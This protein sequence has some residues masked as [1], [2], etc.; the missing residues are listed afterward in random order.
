MSVESKVF[1]G[2]SKSV[3]AGLLLGQ[4]AFGQLQ[5]A[6]PV[7]AYPSSL[8]YRFS[9]V[10]WWSD[11]ELRTLLKKRIP[12]LGD[13]VATTTAGE[14]KIR[15]ALKILL[16]EK[17]IAAEVQSEEPGP[18]AF[19]PVHPEYFPA[20]KAPERPQPAIL[21]SLLAPKVLIDKVQL[22]NPPAE[23]MDALAQEAK[24]FEGR[25]YR[26]ESEEFASYRMGELLEERGF[27]DGKV[28][29]RRD[30]P[31][32]DGD[33]WLVAI[34]A[35]IDAGPRYR[36]SELTADGGPLLAGRDLRSFFGASSGD[37]VGRDPFERL[38]EGLWALYKHSGYADIEVMDDPI[39][40][41]Q[42][43]LVSYH[44]TVNPGP[45]Y[46][47]RTLTIEKLDAAQMAKVRELLG[48]KQGDVYQ[49]DLVDSLYRKVTNEPLL[50]GYKF[51][52]GPRR[53]K[54]AQAIDL[55][56]SFFKEGEE[57]KVTVK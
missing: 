42:R 23:A 39:R 35:E 44:L 29:L 19:A 15:D 57:G 38:K 5:T 4:I 52:F 47:L 55:T 13:E 17:G 31:R 53:D 37:V 10:V 56:L 41:A 45:V 7:G 33:R 26:A 12:G 20:G 43:A 2:V 49:G 1:R 18:L 9:N 40:D 48:M 24:S 8:P 11:D 28:R 16:K 25:P 30:A 46:H 3:L 32:K 54:Q 50:K 22:Q 21:F 6:K 34:R 14:G 51:G 36:I 27:L